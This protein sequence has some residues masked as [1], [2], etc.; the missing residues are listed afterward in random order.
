M[1]VS[2]AG[3]TIPARQSEAAL[4]TE[5][6]RL[7]GNAG[8]TLPASDTKRWSSRRKAAIIVALRTGTITREEA[9]RRYRLSEE[10]LASWEA[11]FD[12]S[13]IP[14]LL[15]TRLQSHR[16]VRLRR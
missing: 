3:S 12:R 1:L 11:A 14:G 7:R 2:D 10:E 5:K 9:C 15:V 4:R 6:P 16:P 8:L 13:G